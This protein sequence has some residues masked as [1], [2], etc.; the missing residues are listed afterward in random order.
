ML[1]RTEQA[2]GRN[3]RTVALV[4]KLRYFPP[5]RF[6]APNVSLATTGTHGRFST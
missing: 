4:G 6:D 1:A 3:E 5:P 2:G